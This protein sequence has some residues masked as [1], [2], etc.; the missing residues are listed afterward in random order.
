MISKLINDLSILKLKIKI[1]YQLK[2]N[3]KVSGNIIN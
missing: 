2:S 1:N 3:E